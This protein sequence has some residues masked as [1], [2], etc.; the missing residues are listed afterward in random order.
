MSQHERTFSAKAPPRRVSQVALVVRNTPANA[1]EKRCRFDLWVRKT[2]W[3]R[4]WLPT[5]VF[6]P[7]ES[8]GQRSLGG[9]SLWGCTEADTTEA[10]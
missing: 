2:R 10:T 8:H 4:K 5:A 7:G 6:L 1:G 3:R 9:Y